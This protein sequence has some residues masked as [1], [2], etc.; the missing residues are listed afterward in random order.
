MKD[1]PF[2]GS[3]EQAG[4]GKKTIAYEQRG[5]VWGAEENRNDDAWRPNFTFVGLH[6]VGRVRAEEIDFPWDQYPAE[7]LGP[8][9]QGTVVPMLAPRAA[10]PCPR[11]AGRI[12]AGKPDDLQTAGAEP[13][14][15][16]SPAAAAG[17][18]ETRDRRAGRHVRVPKLEINY[19]PYNCS[20]VRVP[21]LPPPLPECVTW[22]RLPWKMATRKDEVP[23][24]TRQPDRPLRPTEEWDVGGI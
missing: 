6:C 18:E 12:S 3:H 4:N 5:T 9:L 15:P 11:R 7:P 22:D 13:R 2:V 23:F 14:G 19:T 10:K 8:A 24:T 16:G 17:G 21:G 20:G 1:Y